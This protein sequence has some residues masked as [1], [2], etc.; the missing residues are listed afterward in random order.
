MTDP[1][2]FS[3]TDRFLASYLLYAGLP[4][5]DVLKDGK[6][7]RFEFLDENE[8]GPSLESE[9]LNDGKVTSARELLKAA[10]TINR[11]V[12]NLKYGKQ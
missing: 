5:M 3:T 8:D 9:F 11:E 2:T 7:Q 1:G 12:Y 10:A 4:L 6:G